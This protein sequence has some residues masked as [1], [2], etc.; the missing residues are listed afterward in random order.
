MG[1]GLGKIGHGTNGE[2]RIGQSQLK[3]MVLWFESNTGSH[4]KVKN[5]YIL[6]L[7]TPL[8]IIGILVC[9]PSFLRAETYTPKGFKILIP[10]LVQYNDETNGF[11]INI[12][13]GWKK[14]DVLDAFLKFDSCF[15]LARPY[16]ECEKDDELHEPLPSI[17][18]E[19]VA[20]YIDDLSYSP[21]LDEYLKTYIGYLKGRADKCFSVKII[22]SGD[23]KDGN[24]DSKYII[25]SWSAC[26]DG[27]NIQSIV[28]LYVKKKEVFAVTCDSST[29]RFDSYL[30]YF[31]EIGKSF[32]LLF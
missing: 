1:Q 27:A 4:T 5:S 7:L 30:N 3:M 20:V 28:F 16:Q 31:L 25:Y 26:D 29:D 15:G 19:K 11:S 21:K 13:S 24:I 23:L 9:D 32:K 22:K 6:G 10:K 17:V 12:P 8:F 2:R 14:T 18:R